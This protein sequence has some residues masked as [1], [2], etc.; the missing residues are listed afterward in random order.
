M[1][2]TNNIRHRLI[3]V[4]SRNWTISW[5]IVYI[6]DE[7]YDWGVFL[8]FWPLL[9]VDIWGQLPFLELSLTKQ[10]SVSGN[11][12]ENIILWLAAA[13]QVRIIFGKLVHDC[14]DLGD[15]DSEVFCVGVSQC[16]RLWLFCK[17]FVR[18]FS[19]TLDALQI[20]GKTL[21][22]RLQYLLHIILN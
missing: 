15:A 8:V 2:S 19:P 6:W 1:K 12:V 20:I 10:F 5:I 21:T 11:H 9:E 17:T 22:M 16:C 4:K 18:V 13:I 14:R 3:I 7:G